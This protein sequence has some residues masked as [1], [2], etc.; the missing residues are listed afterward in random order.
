MEPMINLLKLG[1]DGASTRQ[2]LLADNIANASTPFYK[3]KDIDFVSTLKTMVNN[4]DDLSLKV[5]DKDHL[6]SG[7]AGSGKL[8][9]K[10]VTALDNFKYRNDENNVDIDH[11]MAELAKNDIYY[12]TL[13]QQLNVKYRM[14]EDAI[15]KGGR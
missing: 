9:F 14:L 15:Q 11:E 6:D 4:Q 3:R 7:R 13:V 1:L 5:T 8:P 10:K 2:K 12:N